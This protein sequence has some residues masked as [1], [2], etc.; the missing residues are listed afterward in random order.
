[1][2][3]RKVWEEKTGY[4]LS[5]DKNST[6]RHETSDGISLA[7]LYCPETNQKTYAQHS[8]FTDQ[9]FIIHR[10]EI[11][12]NVLMPNALKALMN[13]ATGLEIITNSNDDAQ[14]LDFLAQIDFDAI[15][16]RF[17]NLDFSPKLYKALLSSFSQNSNAQNINLGLDPFSS[18]AKTGGYCVHAGDLTKYLTSKI[19]D[20][21]ASSKIF[22]LSSAI[23]H[24]AGAT[25]AQEIAIIASAYDEILSHSSDDLPPEAICALIEFE[26]ASEADQF[27][28]L[29]KIRAL[30]LILEHIH[31]ARNITKPLPNIHAS[32]SARMISPMDPNVNILRA[33]AACFS[34]ILGGAFSIS[35]LP[36][37]YLEK[38]LDDEHSN[39]IIRNIQLMF[40]EESHL[41]FVKD[42]A[43]GSAYLEN[44]TTQLSEAAW[45][46]F[47][48]ITS[49][50][51]LLEQLK[52]E[53]IHEELSTSAKIRSDKIAQKKIKI[54]GVNIFP[55][56]DEVTTAAKQLE[57]NSAPEYSYCKPLTS[58]RDS[59][60]FESF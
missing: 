30:R 42:P 43:H 34:A 57:Q 32:M 36:H 26:I 24:E 47:Q 3:A 54:T 25:P 46:K 1:M 50:G 33:S 23:F 10:C 11:K 16:C 12:N 31:K 20:H 56:P 37:T 59:E 5:L 21:H 53:K 41:S 51:G 8:Y 48:Q 27:G 22:M 39:R 6:S 58:Q 40:N 13:G 18:I 45:E 28:S 4:V 15:Y 35:L 7:P 52:S 60:S 17:K 9:P 38:G 29:V 44:Y 49:N 19:V 2:T 55:N 14:D